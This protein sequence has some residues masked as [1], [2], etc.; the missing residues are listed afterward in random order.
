MEIQ[1]AHLDAIG[2][3]PKLYQSSLW[4]I[5]KTICRNEFFIWY[6]TAFINSLRPPSG[7]QA[8][9]RWI[10]DGED[11]GR[12]DTP[13]DAFDSLVMICRER[14]KRTEY[15]NIFGTDYPT[16]GRA[17]LVP[18]LHPCSRTWAKKLIGGALETI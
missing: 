5:K 3:R 18:R 17:R 13:G 10:I 7:I 9:G 11:A 4:R 16:D 14:V 15:I 6:S 2:I 12:G 1:Y 8:S